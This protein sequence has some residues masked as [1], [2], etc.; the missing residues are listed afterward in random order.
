M[1]LLLF[2]LSFILFCA[3]FNFSCSGQA[4]K[5]KES[6]VQDTSITFEELYLRPEVEA[7]IPALVGRSYFDINHKKEI[8]LLLIDGRKDSICFYFS[9]ISSKYVLLH[10]AGY[11]DHEMGLAYLNGYPLLVVQQVD[12][13]KKSNV[14]K[15]ITLAAQETAYGMIYEPIYYLYRAKTNGQ[16]KYI[17]QHYMPY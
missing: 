1:K 6:A 5:P 2:N 16:L 8:S 15:Q 3:F 9:T 10:L 14:T 12:Y 11:K 7:V 17:G 4:E 13:L